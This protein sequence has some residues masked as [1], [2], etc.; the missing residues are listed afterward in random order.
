[1]SAIFEICLSKKIDCHHPGEKWK[2]PTWL[3]WR[4]DKTTNI[5]VVINWLSR[6][7]YDKIEDIKGGTEVGCR[8]QA[9]NLDQNFAAE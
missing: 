7:T 1:M 5:P 4:F 3:L 8:S 9:V 6:N 2:D